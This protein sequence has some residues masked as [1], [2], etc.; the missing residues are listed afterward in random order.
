MIR[1]TAQKAVPVDEHIA[2]VVK[3]TT[4]MLDELGSGGRA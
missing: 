3:A 2:L 1:F 4:E